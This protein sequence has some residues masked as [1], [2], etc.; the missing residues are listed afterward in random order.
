MSITEGPRARAGAELDRAIL[1][2]L[3]EWFEQRAKQNALK[4]VL[5]S[6][7]ES[8]RVALLKRIDELSSRLD[9]LIEAT[10]RV[11][12]QTSL[13]ALLQELVR[14]ISQAFQADRSTLFLYDPDTDELF[15]RIAQGD[16]INEIRF[17]ADEGIA[18][19]VFRTGESAI[20]PNAYADPRFNPRIDSETGYTTHSLLCV[21]V[22]AQAGD[23]IGVTEALNKKAG[24]FTPADQALLEAF[25]RHAA[26]ALENAQLSERARASQREESRLIEITQAIS[27]EL[28]LDKL[29]R[30]IMAVATDLL[31]AERSTLFLHDNR[32]D[33]LWSRVAE[34]LQCKEIR[35]ADKSGIAGHVFRS[36]RT[37]NIQDAYAHPLFNPEVDKQTGY[38]TRTVLSVPVID[39]MG[40][41]IGVMQVLNKN[42]GSF[43]KRDERRLEL[44]AAQ[45][46]IALDNARLFMEVLEERN[47]T[48]N[49]L[50]SLSNGVVT[51]DERN[52][53]EKINDA[54]LRTLK[55]DIRD[56]LGRSAE[57]VFTSD[58]RWILGAI[59]KVNETREPDTTLDTAFH[60]D[61]DESVCINLVASPIQDT[62]R[63]T[64]G[65][66]IV[67]EDITKE[68][69]IRATMSR[70]MN[71]ELAEQLI[72]AG[73][74]V[75]GGRAQQATILFTDIKDFTSLSEKL[76][77]QGTVSMLNE[78]F[79]QMV[80]VIFR[81]NGILDK[82]I[83]DAIMAVFGTPFPSPEDPDNAVKVAI[84]MLEVLEDF[85]RR[86]Q[87]LSQ[88]PIEI[89]V[90]INSDEIV[91]GNIG[92]ARRMDYTVV[93]DGV[94][95]ASRLESANKFYGTRILVSGSTVTQLR[96]NY[97]IRELDRIRVKGR[98][99]PVPIYE[100][101]GRPGRSDGD[102]L[103][104]FLRYFDRGLRH[105]REREWQ[106]A[107]GAFAI[108]QASNPD[109]KP[110]R[111]YI[112][113]ARHY[114]VNPPAEDW[115]GVWS[116]T[117]K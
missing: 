64:L 57:Q 7:S 12:Q 50:R 110:C 38:L 41:A 36:K 115:D 105:Y 30:K 58:N 9:A 106:D 33:E 2:P 48:E 108:A 31:D 4:G 26:F 32:R 40:N 43:T 54:A 99:I 42:G 8:E 69:R 28:N 83:G 78:Y 68:K 71:K 45:S 52:R 18:G 116:M 75:L 29:L 10:H 20:V 91:A 62:R 80:D 87:A 25:A 94:N 72:Q 19:A 88:A 107:I 27:S 21:P 51:L 49:I 35:I 44:L 114:L 76:G 97:V 60:R 39:K 63:N 70:Y 24:E 53:V 23:I 67:M 82:Y 14:L 92:S 95:L 66:M 79:G 84:E 37:V 61:N 104:G 98:S 90:G 102:K 77:P 89:R 73:D 74:A 11:Y 113:R 3:D 109:D 1:A 5:A 100:I 55:R 112:E 22:R 13:D 111:I 81:H 101:V 34:G 16:L 96:G 93:G 103:N 117:G 17:R 59:R 6:L 46:A 15:S 85:N 47:Y 56:V 86:R 65:S